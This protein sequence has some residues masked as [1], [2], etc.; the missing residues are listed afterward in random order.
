MPIHRGSGMQRLGAAVVH[1]RNPR[2]SGAMS[3]RTSSVKATIRRW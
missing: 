2:E 1:V 3:C